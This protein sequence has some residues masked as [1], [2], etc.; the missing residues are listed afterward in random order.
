MALLGATSA[1]ALAAAITAALEMATVLGWL[2]ALPILI[3]S[4]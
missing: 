2:K 3:S 1:G 4:C